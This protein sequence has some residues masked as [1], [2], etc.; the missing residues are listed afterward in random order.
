MTSQPCGPRRRNYLATAS[1]IV[2]VSAL[3][4][5]LAGLGLGAVVTMFIGNPISGATMPSAFLPVA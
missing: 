4:S 5:P 3:S 1:F 2:G